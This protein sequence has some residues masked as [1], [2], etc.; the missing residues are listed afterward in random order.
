MNNDNPK[1][2]FAEDRNITTLVFYNPG[3]LKAVHTDDKR[4]GTERNRN[5]H[6]KVDTNQNKLNLFTL[7]WTRECFNK[8]MRIVV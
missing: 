7:S 8:I 5:A 6:S 4:N 1:I 3:K 2:E